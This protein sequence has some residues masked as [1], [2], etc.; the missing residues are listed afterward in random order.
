MAELLGPQADAF[1]AAL[2]TA[3]RGSAWTL[4]YPRF[5]VVVP[6][7]KTVKVPLA[8][9]VARREA[10]FAGFLDT[11][12]DLKRKDGTIDALYAHWILGRSAAARPRRWSILRDVLHWTE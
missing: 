9:P 7:G 6:E 1:D 2:I 4:L 8:Y 12:I 11:F 5:S 10:A 3:E